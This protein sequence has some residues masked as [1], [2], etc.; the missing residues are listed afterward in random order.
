M[1][2]NSMEN[3][4]FLALANRIW[5]KRIFVIKFLTLFLVLGIVVA[6]LSPKEFTASSTFIPQTSDSQGSTE[7]LGGLASLAGIN[8]GGM[9]GGSE[10]PPALYPKIVSSVTF[11]KALLEAP[12]LVEGEEEFVT[13]QTYYDQLHSPGVIE[14]VK[15]NILGLPG[16]IIQLVRGEANEVVTNEESGLIRV[17]AEEFAHFKRLNSQLSVISND[18]E[19]IVTINFVM[20][21][22]LMAAQMAQFTQ[23]LL[24]REI[25]QFKIQNAKEQLKFIE[26]RFQEKK[27]EFGE[28]Q[29]KLGTFRDRNQNLTSSLIINQLQKLEAD[30]NFSFNLYTELAMQVEQARLKVAKDTPVLAVIQ[31]VTVPLKKSNISG[32]I[33][34]LIFIM[35]GFFFSISYLIALEYL[36]KSK[37]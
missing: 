36:G 33:V 17:S 35:V 8:L 3:I 10:I 23:D 22:P 9:T 11:Q 2:D 29:N 32:S 14:L 4:Q 7:G 27:K 31:P 20:P 21:Q 16:L 24:E 25:I 18:K 13:Y 5:A 6:L 12:I 37:G 1:Q 15:K 34:V 26:D 30:Y 19:G 28:I